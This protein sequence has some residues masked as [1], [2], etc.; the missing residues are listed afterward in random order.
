METNKLDRLKEPQ[1]P[2]FAR[3]RGALEY[4]RGVVVGDNPYPENDE[5]H[6]KWLEGWTAAAGLKF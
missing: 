1:E 2:E 6:W 5:Q 3:T 4:S